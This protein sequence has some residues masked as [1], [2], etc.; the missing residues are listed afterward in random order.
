MDLNNLLEKQTVIC[1]MEEPFAIAYTSLYEEGDIWVKIQGCEVCSWESQQLCCG[2]CP[3]LSEAGCYLH[4]LKPN[5]S[6]N[7]PFGCIAHPH[8]AYCRSYCMLEFKCVKGSN[9]DK[10]RCVRDRRGVLR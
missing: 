6:T 3:L 8:P 2:K 7:K 1:S 9:K 4:L 5:N 10:I